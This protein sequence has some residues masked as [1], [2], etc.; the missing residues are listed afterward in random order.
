MGK[1][2]MKEH[3]GMMCP[4]SADDQGTFSL[5]CGDSCMAWRKL[6]PDSEETIYGLDKNQFEALLELSGISY[7]YLM[8]NLETIPSLKLKYKDK[9]PEPKN[10]ISGYCGLAGKP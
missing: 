9:L 7:T 5:C 1:T 2:K 8:N 10:S 6:K 3:I 4:M